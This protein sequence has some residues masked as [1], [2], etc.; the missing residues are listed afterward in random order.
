[1]QKD[2]VDKSAISSYE[3]QKDKIGTNYERTRPEGKMSEFIQGWP[4]DSNLGA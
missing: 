3:E 4:L 2:R 1:M